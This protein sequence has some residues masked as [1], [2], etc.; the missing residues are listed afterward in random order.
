MAPKQLDIDE[1]YTPASNKIPASGYEVDIRI[2][3]ENR[4]LSLNKGWILI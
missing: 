2:N 1:T 4:M 3:N